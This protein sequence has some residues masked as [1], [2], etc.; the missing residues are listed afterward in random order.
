MRVVSGSQGLQL[1]EA[2]NRRR[3]MGNLLSAANSLPRTA[4][5]Q[6]PWHGGQKQKV[7]GRTFCN[8]LPRDTKWQV[9]MYKLLILG[10]LNFG[11][12]LLC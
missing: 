8:F 11:K 12:S 5:A 3:V 7:H 10:G 6:H 9:F 1:A 4:R 2:A